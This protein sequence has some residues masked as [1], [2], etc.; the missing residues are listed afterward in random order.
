MSIK[1]RIPTPLRP[2]VGGEAALQIKAETVIAVLDQIEKDHPGFKSRICDDAGKTRRFVNIFV[3]SEDIRYLD[4]MK[5]ALQDGD[6]VS[7]VP[8]VA[9]GIQTY[10]ERLAGLKKTLKEIAPE[11][12]QKMIGGKEKVTLIDVR[13]SEEYRGGHL[14]FAVSVPRGF[15]EM[16]IEEA[17]TDRAAPLVLYCA[18]GIRSLF[19]TETLKNMGYT[20]VVSMSGGFSGWTRKGFSI[21]TPTLLSEKDRRRYSRHLLIP[22]VGEEGQ[23]KLLK[24]KV[25]IIGAGGLGCPAA[26]YLAAAGCGTLGLVD[27]D[28]V[29]ESNL[30]RQILHTTDRV[31]TSKIK[32][33]MQTLSAFNGDVRIIPFEERISSSNIERI[34]QAFDIVVDGSD[35]FPTRYLVN[36]AC[37][38]L[39]KPC[40]HGSVYRFEGQVTVFD[41]QRGGPCYRCL[42]KE[43]PPPELAPSCADAGVLGVL[44]GVIGL[45]EAVETVKLIL[46]IGDP[47]IGRVV[48]YDALEGSFQTFILRK[49]PACDYCKE[50]AVFPGFIDYDYFC[51]SKGLTTPSPS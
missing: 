1:V 19:A 20:S 38:K 10:Q 8:A 29:D 26:Y 35:N 9:G 37:V 30:Q 36:D 21:E 17:A 34:M 24:S 32:S 28:V 33:A 39:K 16:R 43:P 40:V 5:T 13:E 18:G 31:G 15:L 2:I 46:E 48:C 49:D 7:I 6:T 27:F 51:A 25:L 44:P 50:G 22:E 42:Y 14:P 23:I 45:L 12:V 4:G 11:D 3:N 47:L 41:P